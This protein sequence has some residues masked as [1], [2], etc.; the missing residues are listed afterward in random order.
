MSIDPEKIIPFV[1]NGSVKKELTPLNLHVLRRYK[2]NTLV[3]YNSAVKKFVSIKAWHLFHNAR[4]P[5]NV[6]Q[7]VKV[8]LRASAKANAMEP[9]K[10]RKK[11]VH[12]KHLV[13]LAITLS[14]GKTRDRA[15]FDLA[16]VAF[17][18]MAWLGELTSPTS[19]GKVDP[20]TSVL[21]KDVIWVGL[22][23]DMAAN[24]TIRDAKTCLPGKTQ[25]LRLWPMHNLLCP[26]AWAK[27]GFNDITGHSF[28]VGGA[29][30]RNAMDVSP[31]EI[32]FLGRWVFNCYQ[33]YIREYSK[34]EIDKSTALLAELDTCWGL[35]D[36]Q[37]PSCA[38]KDKKK[39]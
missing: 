35:L 1:T 19:K 20:R 13:H 16:V 22:G 5:N 9:P 39:E 31:T 29:S 34:E 37:S 4:Y 26:D 24:I 21:K 28:R 36:G 32:C 10:E 17:W 14:G 23:H 3:G 18:G 7:R 15:V 12:L 2:P 27:G 11:A 33:L 6:E 8:L 30:F 25:T 38:L